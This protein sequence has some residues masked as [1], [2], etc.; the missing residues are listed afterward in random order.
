MKALF[1][2][3]ITLG[4]VALSQGA[5]AMQSLVDQKAPEFT[6]PSDRGDT[7]SLS[8][9]KGKQNVLLAF[10]PKAFTPG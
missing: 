5:P 7:V 3:S 2:A 8:Q 10:F 1:L 6:L 4:L 9:F